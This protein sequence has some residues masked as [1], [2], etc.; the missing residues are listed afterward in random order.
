MPCYKY[1]VCYIIDTVCVRTQ[2][3]IWGL[4]FQIDWLYGLSTVCLMLNIV[5]YIHKH[6]V[7]DV[8]GIG[9][10]D[11]INTGGDVI[12][13]ESNV[14]KAVVMMSCSGCYEI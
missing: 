5:T 1:S 3:H 10:R 6:S 12:C 4:R 9:G 13:R 14:M 7:C 11:V 2:I 8:T